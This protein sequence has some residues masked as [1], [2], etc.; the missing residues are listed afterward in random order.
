M[1]EGR[2]SPHFTWAE[3]VI[4]AQR[5]PATG[6]LL[7][8]SPTGS[9]VEALEYTFRHGMEQVRGICGDRPIMVHS[10]FRSPL[11]NARVGGSPR[12]QHMRGEAVD[13]HV[14]GISVV[15]AWELIRAAPL[16][17]DQLILETETWVHVSFV[18]LPTPRRQVLRMGI[19]DGRA[20]YTPV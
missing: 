17:F 7:A 8:N 20:V 4:T 13:F 12:S 14:S 16:D 5:D 19:V 18:R 9:E 15:D 11:V 2:I 1:N 10:A 3:A 6:L